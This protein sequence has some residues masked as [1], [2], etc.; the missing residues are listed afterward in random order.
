MRHRGSQACGA[1][2]DV[3]IGWTGVLLPAVRGG[4]AP[5]L[6]GARRLSGLGSF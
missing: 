3:A 5:S 4:S 6:A 1:R 2:D